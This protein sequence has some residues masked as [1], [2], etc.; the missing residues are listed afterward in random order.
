MGMRE[1]D[2]NGY[3]AIDELTE[4]E[5]KA[6]VR[7]ALRQ[8]RADVTGLV[9]RV[10]VTLMQDYNLS[11]KGAIFAWNWD[12]FMSVFSRRLVTRELDFTFKGSPWFLAVKSKGWMKMDD[13]SCWPETSSWIEFWSLED[14]KR[15]S[16]KF[17]VITETTQWCRE[18]IERA[19]CEVFGLAPVQAEKEPRGVGGKPV[20]PDNGWGHILR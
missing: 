14:G 11:S 3:V 9:L 8:A 6:A 20:H 4:E 16:G 17:E 1:A 18:D 5:L 19:V 7:K 12:V 13:E 15:L 10:A 2:E